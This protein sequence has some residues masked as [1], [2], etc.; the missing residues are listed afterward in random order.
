MEFDGV[1]ITDDMTMGAIADNYDIGDAAVQ[2][3]MAGTDIILVCHDYEKQV[4]IIESLKSAVADGTI[5]ETTIDEHVYRILKL[6][7][8]Y[9]LSNENIETV[10]VEEINSKIRD[11]L[12]R[13][14]KQRR[15]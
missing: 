2:S 6:K 10:D 14:L 5:P 15:Y 7:Q 4:K 1:V 11:I 12:Y 9:K 13:Y 3:I 8:K